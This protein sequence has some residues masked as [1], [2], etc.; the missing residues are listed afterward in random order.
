M[1]DSYYTEECTFAD[2]TQ[3]MI[4]LQSAKNHDYG[5]AYYENL[6]DEKL[7]AARIAIGNKWRRFKN[8]SNIQDRNVNE[9]L[10]DTLIDLASYAIMT[11]QWLRKHDISSNK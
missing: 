4:N 9:P 3:E 6:D 10:E 1:I 11:V 2:V 5:G 7:A 8:I